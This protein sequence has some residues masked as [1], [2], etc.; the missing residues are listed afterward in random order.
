MRQNS[1]LTGLELPQKSYK[2]F[3]GKGLYLI[4]NPSG[5][6]WWRFKYRFDN[7]ERSL[8]LGVYPDV[9]LSSARTKRKTARRLIAEEG[10]DPGVQ[11]RAEKTA[12]II[13]EADF[14][15]MRR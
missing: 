3:D 7:Q 10:I 14:W 1:D 6:H 11:R 13:A 9:G 4:V 8:A 12:R 2:L 15:V 5:R